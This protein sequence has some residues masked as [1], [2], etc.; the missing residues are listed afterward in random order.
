MNKKLAL[1]DIISEAT[2]YE[3]IRELKWGDKIHCLN[4]GGQDIRKNGHDNGISYKQRYICKDCNKTF[5]DISDT[6]MASNHVPIKKWIVCWLL[7]DHISNK[8]LAKVLEL[9]TDIVSDMRGELSEGILKV[10]YLKN[11]EW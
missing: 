5:T 2:C 4:C 8:E 6:V 11:W 3:K 7:K 10:N 1:L 9:D